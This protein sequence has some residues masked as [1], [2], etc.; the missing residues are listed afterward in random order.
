MPWIQIK[1]QLIT[2]RCSISIHLCMWS[3]MFSFML[4]SFL[5]SQSQ[6]K[7]NRKWCTQMPACMHSYSACSAFEY[8]NIPSFKL[9]SIEL[10][11]H[12]ND[13]RC[14]YRWAISFSGSHFLF[15]SISTRENRNLL[16]SDQCE[17]WGTYNTH[18]YLI[19]IDSYDFLKCPT[20]IW[21]TECLP[22]KPFIR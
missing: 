11:S 13:R 16:K 4:L 20:G 10:N 7:Q 1:Q 14:D 15:E 17:H 2:H 3:N 5:T 21:C 22:V 19:T 8:P 6:S 18:A 12:R 9:N